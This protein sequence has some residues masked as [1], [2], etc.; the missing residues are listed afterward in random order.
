MYVRYVRRRRRR[1]ARESGRMV[2]VLPGARGE[3]GG[4]RQG[5]LARG[6]WRSDAYMLSAVC[7][8]G[9]GILAACS[10]RRRVRA[11][12]SEDTY[13]GDPISSNAVATPRYPSSSCVP[14]TS[15]E[16][17][18]AGA[19]AT[20]VSPAAAPSRSLRCVLEDV[21]CALCKV[22]VVAGWRWSK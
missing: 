7:P 14:S 12:M 18:G 10:R 20:M 8:S 17:A 21:V 13:M 5:A 9:I 2:S 6:A 15:R 16:E 19:G 3:V 11:Q 4:R 1:G 22:V